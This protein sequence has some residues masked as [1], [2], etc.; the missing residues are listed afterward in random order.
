MKIRDL[1]FVVDIGVKYKF[2]YKPVDKT[3]S[4][5]RIKIGLFKK[6]TNS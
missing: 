2:G 6:L 1:F 3:D 4:D 5:L